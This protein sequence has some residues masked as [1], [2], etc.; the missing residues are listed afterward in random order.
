MEGESY[1]TVDPLS[2]EAED[3]YRFFNMMTGV[4]LY[5]TDETERDSI[6]ENSPDFTFEGTAFSA[7]ETEVEGTIPVYRFF[8]TVT[9]GH[10]YTPSAEERDSVEELSDYES[11]GIAYY[12]FP[13]ED[14]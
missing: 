4:H 10:F 12:A 8:N 9:G 11:E 3:V 6:I 13:I 2:G 7:Y 1:Q 5:T 14:V